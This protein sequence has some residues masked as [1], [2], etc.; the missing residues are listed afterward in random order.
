MLCQAHHYIEQ[1]VT[2][3]SFIF[4]HESITIPLDSFP[5]I[6]SLQFSDCGI[7]T[8]PLFIKM[9]NSEDISVYLWKK[10]PWKKQNNKRKGE[11]VTHRTPEF[12]SNPND[13]MNTA[14]AF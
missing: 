4:F 1:L 6:F 13:A 5:L 3:F 7:C 9:C 12:P 10:L 2:C 11:S 8:K 14:G